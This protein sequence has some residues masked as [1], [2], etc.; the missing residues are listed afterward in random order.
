MLFQE[1][2]LA[3]VPSKECI[4]LQAKNM[5]YLPKKE[6]C[7][8]HKIA[9]R[10]DAYKYYENHTK[11]KKNRECPYCPEFERVKLS[12]RVWDKEIKYGQA[13]SCTGDSGGPLWKWMNVNKKRKA[14]IM[15]LFSFPI[16]DMIY[17]YT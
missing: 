4:K 3:L 15:H 12:N 11:P 9:R 5:N 8:G 2:K 17:Y 6:L 13:D 7:A 16:I 1:V 10:I 14:R